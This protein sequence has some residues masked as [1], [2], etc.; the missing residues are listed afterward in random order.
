MEGQKHKDT[1][2]KFMFS[3]CTLQQSLAVKITCTSCALVSTPKMIKIEKGD[4]FF[5][6]STYQANNVSLGVV[7]HP[8]CYCNLKGIMNVS[9]LKETLY[10]P[11]EVPVKYSFN[12]N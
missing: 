8:N 3:G 9:S 12:C 1:F 5:C 7:Y 2:S 11:K 4:L 6:V 10:F